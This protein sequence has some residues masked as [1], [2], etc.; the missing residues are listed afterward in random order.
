MPVLLTSF[1]RRSSGNSAAA[2]TRPTSVTPQ[3]ACALP[4]IG[5][6]LGAGPQPKDWAT[7]SV[8]HEKLLSGAQ[9]PDW[10]CVAWGAGHDSCTDGAFDA[11][12]GRCRAQRGDGAHLNHCARSLGPWV[13]DG[14]VR[15]IRPGGRGRGQGSAWC[16]GAAV[17]SSH[18]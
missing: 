14:L 11:I 6:R 5:R 16:H 3:P 2:E 7:I 4:A 15:K 9:Q 8:D 10:L 18:H 17:D 13:H 1:F 12:S